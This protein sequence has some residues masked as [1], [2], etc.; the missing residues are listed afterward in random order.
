VKFFKGFALAF[1]MLSILPFFRV[2]DFFRG[3]NGYAVLSYP[4]VG[5]I[6]GLL[7]W[8]AGVL[9]SPFL[10]PLHLG[11]LLFG[12]WVLLTGA[13]HLDGFA[14]TVDGLF[15]AKERALE[16]MKD[17][18][19]GAMGMLFSGVFL[20]LK[21]SALA[22]VE[23]L[24][25]LPLVLMLSRFN[26]SLAIYFFPYVSKNGMS[27]LAKEEF[28]RSQLLFSALYVLALGMWLSWVLVVVSLLVL[29]A[30]AYFFTRRY[31]GFTG[32]IYGFMI[33]K[34]ELVLLHAI[35]FGSTF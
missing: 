8:G 11:V 33:E 9:L 16:V 35:L 22:H 15:V 34:T 2:H 5:A 13:L 10:P 6:L 28:T 20:L 31:G 4:L 21:A 29:L 17:P 26:A 18:H 19:V 1:S 30:C 7:L 23:A 12:M 24:Y 27:T 32:D 3:I 25:L 14:D